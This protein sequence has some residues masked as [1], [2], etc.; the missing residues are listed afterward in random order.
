M[1]GRHSRAA[2]TVDSPLEGLDSLL[3]HMEQAVREGTD[4][5]RVMRMVTIHPARVLGLQDRL[6]TI[7]NGKDANFAVFKGIPG[8]D[9]GAHVI[10]TI[11]EGDLKYQAKS[12][13]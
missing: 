7:E 9:M 8:T 4:P 10:Y 2:L 13:L 1:P 6:G 3:S 5:L 12:V 11:G